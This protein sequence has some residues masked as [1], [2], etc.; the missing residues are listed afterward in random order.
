MA[1]RA[2]AVP[3]VVLAGHT[4]LG[5]PQR[6]A[7]LPGSGGAAGAGQEVPGVLFGAGGDVPHFQAHQRIDAAVAQAGAGPPAGLARHSPPPRRAA[8]PGQSP[9]PDRHAA[10]PVESR[11]FDALEIRRGA[12]RQRRRRRSCLPS[13][14]GAFRSNE[15]VSHV[16]KSAL[17]CFLWQLSKSVSSLKISQRSL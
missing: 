5:K 3:G 16:A 10:G 15:P 14:L 12:A 6:G 1:R 13:L 8:R 17:S 9:Q 2:A 4:D 11:P 7:G